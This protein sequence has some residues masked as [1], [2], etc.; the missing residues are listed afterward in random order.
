VDVVEK[1]SILRDNASSLG[2]ADWWHDRETIF[3]GTARWTYLDVAARGLLPRSSRNALDR[4]LDSLMLD[5][6]DK[7]SMFATV[8]E[9]R[10]RFARLI[11]ASSDEIAITKNISEGINIVALAYPW[12][13]GDRVVVCLEREH[14]NNVYIWMHLARRVGIEVQAVQSREGRIV[15][16]D[17]IAAL[18]PRVRML[19]VSST[20]FLPGLR[21]DL[22]QLGEACGERGVLLLVDGAQSVGL[23]AHDVRR[24]GIDALAA[25]TQKGLLGLY[26]MGFLYCRREW[27]ERLEPVYLARFGV[28][29]GD[30]HEADVDPTGY[31]LKSGALRFDLGNYNFPAA[32]AVNESLKLLLDYGIDK[33]ELHVTTLARL[34]IRGLKE[35]GFF[36]WP[37]PES[38]EITNI[39]TVGRT[40]DDAAAMENLH[41]TL[42]MARI[43]LSVRRGHLRFSFHIYNTFDD[44]EHVLHVAKNWIRSRYGSHHVG[45]RADNSGSEPT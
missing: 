1:K 36:V 3:P 26:G 23:L 33:V 10:D 19:S 7:P 41:T 21:T 27:A 32:V 28:E 18:G 24:T 29:L 13:P 5:A 4:H 6:G 15:V 2:A 37:D 20:S 8:E 43:R 16:S 39:V 25:S 9:A 38:D 14:P 31:Q 12:Q 35:L 22:D 34:L 30:A 11:G 44:V 40:E 45:R 17:L 42:S